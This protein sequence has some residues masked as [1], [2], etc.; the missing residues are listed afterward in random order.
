MSRL[1]LKISFRGE[2]LV[3]SPVRKLAVFEKE[4]EKKRIKVYHLNIGDPDL[5]PHPVFLKALKNF[6]KKLIPYSDSKGDKDF[7]KALL[8]YYRKFG[9]KDLDEENFQVTSGASEAILWAFSIVANPGQE[10]VVCEPFYCNYKAYA[11]QT[12]IK[13]IPILTSI[14]NGFHLPPGKK[15]I[16]KISSKTKAIL[17][18]NPNNPT[19]TVLR[20]EEMKILI[21]IAREN[22]LWLISDETYRELVFDGRKPLS[23]LNFNE[24]GE[25]IIVIDSLSK[26]YSLPGLRL[27]ALVSK[28]KKF[29]ETALKYAQARLGAGFLDQKIGSQLIKVPKNHF[30]TIRNEYQTR[31]DLTFELL[32]K[33]EGVSCTK[34]EGAFYLLAK[35]P[36]DDCEEFAKWLLT[37]FQINKETIMVTPATDFYQTKGLGKDEIRIAY[38]I[39]KRDLTKS[40]N[41]LKEGLK[42]YPTR[43]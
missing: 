18:C 14:E 8:L 26:I 31:R 21:K 29:I 12:G 35:L 40:I 34:P 36:I 19:G 38:V 33:I 9:I 17:I 25:G 13:L 1:N 24:Y 4:A 42:V 37:G 7:L 15:I 11:Q 23:F 3:P 28:N 5:P 32:N 30:E 16:E 10:I 22:S 2:N 39:N 27:G 20:E 6:K 43:N 41:I